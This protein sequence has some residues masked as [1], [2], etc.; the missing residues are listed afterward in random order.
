[1]I[2][3]IDRVRVV[4]ARFDVSTGRTLEESHVFS[5]DYFCIGLNGVDSNIES[6]LAH[7]RRMLKKVVKEE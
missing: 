4:V 7:V 5:G 1:M 6:A 3:P 2:L